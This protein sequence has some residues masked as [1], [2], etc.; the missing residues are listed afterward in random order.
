MATLSLLLS[1]II[2][3]IVFILTA[4]TIRSIIR[5]S[6]TRNSST[7]NL[8]HNSPLYKCKDGTASEESEA[9]YRAAVKVSSIILLI[10]V[11]LALLAALAGAVLQLLC[12]FEVSR[13]SLVICIWLRAA[14]WVRYLER[15]KNGLLL[16]NT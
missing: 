2:T 16:A 15:Q 9:Q 8:L 4:T 14:A 6:L 12:L 10:N 13:P 3:G 5:I 7:D 11:L 1:S